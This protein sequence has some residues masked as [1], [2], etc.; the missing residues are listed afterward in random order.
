MEPRQLFFDLP[1]LGNAGSHRLI[2]Y[3]WGN[4][5]AARTVLCVHGLTRNGRDFDMLAQVL[6]EKC[7]V[8]C[9]DMPGRGKS[10]WLPDPAAYNYQTYVADL[11]YM[12]R[13]LRLG[14]VQWVGTSMGGIIA[15]MMPGLISALVLNDVGCL[16]PANGLQ[17]ILSY[18]GARGPSSFLTRADAEAALRVRA[19]TFGIPSEAHWQHLFVHGI[20]P[21]PDGSFRLA[22]D[23]AIAA[24]FPQ[25]KD[26]SDV[27]L[28]PLWNPLR[29]IPVL[30]IRGAQSDILTHDTAVKMRERHS[31]LTLHEIAG[32]GHAPA[33]MTDDQI[34]LI[35]DWLREAQQKTHDDF[36]TSFM[37]FFKRMKS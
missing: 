29:E 10:E 6:A 32:V 31:D 1:N 8:L 7:R 28:W 24:G 15:M 34:G 21:A 11:S 12:L 4:P 27:N 5:K 36:K 17:R 14:Q 19:A 2:C 20:E 30:L 13:E 35:A 22:F 25:E 3:E 16:I 37:R 33:L 23:P 18:A 9:P 26:I